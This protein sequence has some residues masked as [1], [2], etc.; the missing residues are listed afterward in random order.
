MVTFTLSMRKGLN[1][2]CSHSFSSS[3]PP[4]PSFCVLRPVSWEEKEGREE[5]SCLGLGQARLG[6]RLLLLRIILLPEP[7]ACSTLCTVLYTALFFQIGEGRKV[8]KLKGSISFR[9]HC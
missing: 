5:Q 3:P 1:T 8:A 7:D 4:T 6:R 2:F 9:A